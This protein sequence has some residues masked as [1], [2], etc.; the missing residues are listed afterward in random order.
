MR[1]LRVSDVSFPDISTRTSTLPVNAVGHVLLSTS[2]SAFAVLQV[3]TRDADF[4]SCSDGDKDAM[5]QEF[6]KN[7]QSWRD[8]AAQAR[9]VPVDFPLGRLILVTGFYKT[10]NWAAMAM[11]SDSSNGNLDFSVKATGLGGG[12][13]SY[14]WNDVQLVSPAR[15]SGH[16]HPPG[17]A[18]PPAT[19]TPTSE[20]FANSCRDHSD[21]RNQCIFLRGF[22]YRERE[23]LKDKLKVLDPVDWIPSL[24]GNIFRRT[25]NFTSTPISAIPAVPPKAPSS[26]SQQQQSFS[27]HVEPIDGLPGPGASV[28][29]LL[30]KC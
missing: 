10:W 23:L 28:R 15:S 24:L 25:S 14:D 7:A 1:L 8:D 30:N 4:F 11:S 12:G 18:V 27:A 2:H 29:H 17:L 20:I 13:L 5:G 26:D 9:I 3:E 21:V 16:R 22:R 6:L 19:A